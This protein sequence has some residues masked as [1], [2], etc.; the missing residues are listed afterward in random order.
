MLVQAHSGMVNAFWMKKEG[1][2]AVRLELCN[3]HNG[4]YT[5][6]NRLLASYRIFLAAYAAVN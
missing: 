6:Q 5:P 1:I 4:D 3:S 2:G